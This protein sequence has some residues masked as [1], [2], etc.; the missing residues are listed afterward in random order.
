[1]K[2]GYLALIP[3]LAASTAS[4]AADT[5]SKAEAQTPAATVQTPAMDMRCFLISSAAQQTLPDENM[6]QIAMLTGLFYL[7]RVSGRMTD[8]EMETSAFNEAKA[9]KTVDG[10]KVQSLFVQCGEFMGAKGQALQSLGD[11]LAEAERREAEA[12]K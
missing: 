3:A 12:K 1:M 9:L 5:A 4:L 8:A 6:R 10:Q 11:R 7:G 2:L